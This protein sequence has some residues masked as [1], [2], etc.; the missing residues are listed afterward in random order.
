[1]VAHPLRQAL[2]LAVRMVVLILFDP[3]RAA[4]TGCKPADANKVAAVPKSCPDGAELKGCAA[5]RRHGNLVRKRCW[6]RAG[7]GRCLRR[8]QPERRQNDRGHLPRRKTV[9]RMDD[10]ACQRSAL[11]SR[12]LHRRRTERDYTRAGTPTAPRRSRGSTATA[13]ARARGI[14]GTPTGSRQWTDVY[15]DDEKIS[16][17]VS[18]GPKTKIP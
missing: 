14:D 6:R 18:D 11:L 2:R 17:D 13:N 5:A 4:L 8:L 3:A 1:M 10:V 9:G 16:G 15:K 7:Q 12:P